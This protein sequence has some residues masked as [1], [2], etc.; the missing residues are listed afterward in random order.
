MPDRKSTGSPP[1]IHNRF[2]RTSMVLRYLVPG[3]TADESVVCQAAGFSHC[4]P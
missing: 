1:L 4:V 2:C 3:G